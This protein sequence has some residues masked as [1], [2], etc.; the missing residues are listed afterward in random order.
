MADVGIIKFRLA[1]IQFGMFTD[2]ILEIVR[3]EK[4]RVIPRPLP[5]VIGLM[6]LRD[7]IVV[8]ADLRKR[9]GLTP[10]PLLP[11]TTMIVGKYSIGMVGILVESI[12]HFRQASE[13]E[14]LPPFAIAGF[15]ADL[16]HGVVAEEDEILLIPDLERLFSSYIR[17]QLLPIS[18]S[19]KIAFHYRDVSGGIT[20]TL[21]TVLS[22]QRQLDEGMIR[23]MSHAMSLPPVQAHKI[24]SYYTDFQ[25]QA[26]KESGEATASSHSFQEARAGDESY[27]SLSKHAAAQHPHHPDEQRS[28]KTRESI[29]TL[30]IQ[31]PPNPVLPAIFE[32]TL[33]CDAAAGITKE[34]AQPVS[35]EQLAS[36]RDIG[37]LAAAALRIPPVRLRRYFTYYQSSA[38]FAP[39]HQKEL[40]EK[41]MPESERDHE[42]LARLQRY[43]TSRLRLEDVLQRLHERR[44]TLTRCHIQW[45]TQQYHLSLLQLAKRLHDYRDIGLDLRE[46]AAPLQDVEKERSPRTAAPNNEHETE[47]SVIARQFSATTLPEWMSEF[48]KAES[49]ETAAFRAIAARLRIPTCRLHKL[50]TYYHSKEQ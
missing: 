31:L 18:Y 5:Y 24:S 39:F 29:E 41:A 9:L 45:L 4:F 33:H 27:M 22:L 3:L 11:G 16:L 2:Q 25:P 40:S 35:A 21:E 50:H 49:T 13:K 30:R 20:R 38:T 28:L 47:S 14:I 6:E 23:K 46:D 34:D 15:P 36:Q 37:R 48:I 7:Y 12:S 19:E 17:V 26:V 42:L 32:A 10:L 8:I 1:N 44:D 43:A